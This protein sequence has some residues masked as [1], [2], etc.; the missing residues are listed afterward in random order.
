MDGDIKSDTSMITGIFVGDALS[1]P[2]RGLRLAEAEMG[3]VKCIRVAGV[4]DLLFMSDARS[5]TVRLIAVD[6]TML[7]RLTHVLPRLRTQFPQA[8][9]A[10]AFRHVEKACELMEKMQHEPS[11]GQVGLLPMNLHIDCWLSVL[12]LL[13]SGEYLIPAELLQREQQQAAEPDASGRDAS[14]A[15]DGPDDGTDVHLTARELQ[16]LQSASEG[17]QNKIIADELNLSQHTIK[18]HMHHIIAKL[19]VHN[20]TEAAV[21]YLGRYANGR[22]R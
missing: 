2:E 4:N 12:Q 16:V 6:E 20:R 13:I 15:A 11:W 18:L 19:R 9:I 17:K 5:E 10:L 8:N 7:D 3:V 22:G 21:W 14:P 1:F